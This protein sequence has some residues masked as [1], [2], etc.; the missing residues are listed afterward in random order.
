MTPKTH[1][2]NQARAH[3]LDTAQRQTVTASEIVMDGRQSPELYVDN[4]QT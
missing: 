2:P 4:S 3:N 1:L